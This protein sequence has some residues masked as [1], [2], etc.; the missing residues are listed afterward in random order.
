LIPID[1]V[2]IQIE[3]QTDEPNVEMNWEQDYEK[4]P[5]SEWFT[6]QVVRLVRRRLA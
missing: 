3:H 1:E 2:M 4:G 5:D 6:V